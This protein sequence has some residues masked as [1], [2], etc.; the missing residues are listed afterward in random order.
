[1]KN[2]I[3]R[4]ALGTVVL[5]AV[6]VSD[7]SA[8]APQQPSTKNRALLAVKVR[9]TCPSAPEL[10]A[11]YVGPY[12][13]MEN[14][15]T[16]EDFAE[17]LYCAN[18][19]KAKNSPNGYVTVFG[20]SSIK[21][22]NDRGTPEMRAANNHLYD[23]V[24]AFAKDW[25]QQYGKNFPIMT[26]AGPGLME[27]ASRGARE[28]G[29]K[30]IGYTTYYD[31]PTPKSDPRHPYGGDKTKVFNPENITD[32]LI[33]SSIAIREDMMILHSAAIIIAPG[34]TGTEWE[35][36][37]ILETLKSKQLMPVPVYL[38]GDRALYWASFVEFLCSMDNHATLKIGG[39]DFLEFVDD[40]REVVPRLKSRLI[41]GQPSKPVA[42]TC[43]V[44]P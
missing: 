1:L 39:V 23:Y 31:D 21:Q 34:G 43:A 38:V 32:G 17:D 37:Q 8:D 44:L 20:S 12:L 7:A 26:G 4:T 25:T 29:D 10:N 13:G 40:P 14:N 42:P 28:A 36:F 16:P 3:T 11:R 5:L 30:S 6:L 24:K 2:F 18:E 35:T 27:A 33:F 22:E 19:F 41:D 9:G 15:L